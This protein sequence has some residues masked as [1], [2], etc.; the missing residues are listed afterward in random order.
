MAAVSVILEHARNDGRWIALNERRMLLGAGR[1]KDEALGA[2]VMRI[3][4]VDPRAELV[5]VYPDEDVAAEY[6]A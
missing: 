2:A 6:A 3:L 5:V 4:A 1:T